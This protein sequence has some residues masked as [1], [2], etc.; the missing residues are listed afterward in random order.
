M[1]GA[2]PTAF[3]DAKCPVHLVHEPRGRKLCFKEARRGLW[4]ARNTNSTI[5]SLKEASLV[6][7]IAELVMVVNATNI[8]NNV[9]GF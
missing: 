8:Y 6:M 4:S 3:H 9:Q 7:V 5:E 2:L 1:L